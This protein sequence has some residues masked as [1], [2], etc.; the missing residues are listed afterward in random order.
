MSIY[1]ILYESEQAEILKSPF[2]GPIH[3]LEE[4]IKVYN[5]SEDDEDKSDLL[6]TILVYLERINSLMNNAGITYTPDVSEDEKEETFKNILVNYLETANKFLENKKNTNDFE[7]F[8]TQN[9]YL[10]SLVDI[11]RTQYVKEGEILMD[12]EV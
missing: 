11:H 6:G 2:E 3:K 8:N 7:S 12:P 1:R 10:T 5:D 4:A 9:R